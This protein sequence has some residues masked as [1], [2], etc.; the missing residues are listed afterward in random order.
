[1]TLGRMITES[2]D[3]KSVE[4]RQRIYALEKEGDE[5]EKNILNYLNTIYTYDMTGEVALNI[6]SL[7]GICH[8]LESIGDIALKTAE[9]HRERKKS[10]SF[11][12]PKLRMHLLELHDSLSVA[13]TTLVQ[14]LNETDGN[15]NLKEAKTN[16]KS[17]DKRFREADQA[18]LKVIEKD[19]LSALSAL[20]YKELIQSYEQIGD[21]LYR[22]NK[23]LGK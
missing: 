13:T 11:I 22:A 1:N 19:K 16:E 20:L 18:L 14:N 15:V 7:V 12:T 17:I 2:D 21:H 9:V 6:Q 4:L 3:E 8:H 23:A 10:N 5:L